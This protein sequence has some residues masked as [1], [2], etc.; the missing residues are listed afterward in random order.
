LR[1]SLLF[2]VLLLTACGDLS[3]LPPIP[4]S[5]TPL[6][7]T[8]LDDLLGHSLPVVGVEITTVGYVV[9]DDAGARLLDGLSFS[10]GTDPQP[11]A[12][13]DGQIWLTGDSLQT[14]GGLLR[15]GGALRYAVVLARGRLEGPGVY[16]PD[17][18]YRY[19]MR[20]PQ[21]QTLAPEETNIMTL[22]ANANAYEGRIVRIT[23]ALLAH[24]GSA[25]LVERLGAGGLPEEGARQLKLRG[26]IRD[27]E[28]LGRLK[29]T[30][31]GIY[32]GQVQV[33]GFWRSGQ[34]T[35]LAILP[36]S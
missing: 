12:G 9:V 17:G 26:P 13:A 18:D 22:S 11:L 29:H 31:S 21:L 16:G 35:P 15:G 10:A 34:L 24:S 28:L 14:L 32:F 2:M 1:I 23:G 6:S 3:S 19:H 4:P 25:L 8:P 20:D 5:P 30:G 27:Q 36:V 7:F 33:E